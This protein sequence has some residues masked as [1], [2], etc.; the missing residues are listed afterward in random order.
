MEENSEDY[1]GTTKT[2]GKSDKAGY[3]TAVDKTR[4]VKK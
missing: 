1:F 3:W 4:S 2:Y